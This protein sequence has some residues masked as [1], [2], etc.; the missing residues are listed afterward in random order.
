MCLHI[1]GLIFF[2][3]D[4]LSIFASFSTLLALYKSMEKKIHVKNFVFLTSELKSTLNFRME[5]ISCSI[6]WNLLFAHF[7]L[8]NVSQSLNS[9]VSDPWGDMIARLYTTHA[10]HI[11]NAPFCTNQTCRTYSFPHI[12]RRNDQH[13][14]TCILLYHSKNL[15]PINEQW[16]YKWRI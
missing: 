5:N 8:Q 13:D 14:C 7:W 10:Q 3:T 16:I 4:F 2:Y 11:V 15:C 1:G 9:V 6:F 12:W